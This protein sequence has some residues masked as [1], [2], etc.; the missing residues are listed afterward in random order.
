MRF[1]AILRSAEGAGFPPP[2]LLEGIAKLGAEA[3]KAGV[4]VDTAGLLPAATATRVCVAD[5]EL[6]VTQGVFHE[7]SPPLAAYTIYDVATRDEV[8]EW[9]T[10]FME[11]HRQTWP[12][13][14]GE[15]EIRQLVGPQA[16]PP[17]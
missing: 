14:E 4:L 16:S 9:T 5:G 1:I 2:P 15:S 17:A 8:V 13:W 12:G 10:R 3:T 11:L 6:T 7:P